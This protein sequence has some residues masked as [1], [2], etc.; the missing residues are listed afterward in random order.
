MILRGV[1]AWQGQGEG[2]DQ[3]AANGTRQRKLR[4]AGTKVTARP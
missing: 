1:L 3:R 4:E 2:A